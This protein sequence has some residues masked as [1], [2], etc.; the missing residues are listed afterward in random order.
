MPTFGSLNYGDEDLKS[1]NLPKN[2]D[3]TDGDNCVTTESLRIC[4][5]FGL[6]QK[7]PVFPYHVF[8]QTHAG[9]MGDVQTITLFAEVI[10]GTHP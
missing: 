8:N 7:A 1:G 6:H 2:I 5:D 4:D 10:T 3:M 9:M